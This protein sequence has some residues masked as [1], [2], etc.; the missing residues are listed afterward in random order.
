[1]NLSKITDEFSVAAGLQPQAASAVAA[2]GAKMVIGTAPD[3]EADQTPESRLMQA[4]LS[5]AGVAFAHVPVVI[6]LITD[7][8]VRAFAQALRDAEGPVVAYC[9]SGLRATL[10]WALAMQETFGTR[11]VIHLADMAGF[12]I[13]PYLEDQG[14]GLV[15]A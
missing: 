15:A 8:Q 2:S 4:Q 6:G 1:M 3:R 14:E 13:A 5:S 9:H 11:H 10:L 7:D 12:D